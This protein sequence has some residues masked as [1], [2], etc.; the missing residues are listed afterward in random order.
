MKMPPMEPNNRERMLLD[1]R[2]LKSLLPFSASAISSDVR[3]CC[4]IR[5][6]TSI[7]ASCFEVISTAPRHPPH[8]LDAV[9][10]GLTVSGCQSDAGR[11][12]P[13]TRLV[14]VSAAPEHL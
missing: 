9:E 6:T 1:F 12:F 7:R 2:A 14:A 4:L 3:P 13:Q 8:K 10:I 11:T 5:S